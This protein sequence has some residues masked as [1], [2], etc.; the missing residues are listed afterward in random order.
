MKVRRKTARL[1]VLALA[2]ALALILSACAQTTT[3]STAGTTAT[4]KTT[5]K[6]TTSATSGQP[7]ELME[8]DKVSEDVYMPVPDL[9]LVDEPVSFSVLFPRRPEHGDFKTM[10]Y[11]GHLKDTANITLVFEGVEQTGWVEKKNLAFASGEYSDI[12][13]TGISLDDANKY[14]RE[15]MLLRLNDLLKDYSPCSMKLFAAMPTTLKNITDDE[16][17]IYMMPS[18]GINPRDGVWIDGFINEEWLTKAGVAMPKT[19]DDLYIA[20]KA[21][22]TGDGNGNG[23]ED[24]IPL[25]FRWNFNTNWSNYYSILG[26]YGFVGTMHDVIDGNYVYVPVQENYRHFLSYMNKLYAEEL[27]DNEVFTQ[28]TE[29]FTAKCSEYRVGMAG[30]MQNYF[31]DTAKKEAY[32]MVGCLTSEYNQE[33]MWPVR[34]SETTNGSYCITDK[35][36]YPE[37][38]TKL[39]DFFY[40][41]DESFII[42]SGP[43]AGKWDGYG[44]WSR[45][46]QADGSFLS[47]VDWDKDKY[48]SFWLH[49]LATAPM[50]MPFVYTI[51]HAAIVVDSSPDLVYQAKLVDAIGI[52]DYRRLSYPPG[53]SFTQDEQDQL[54]TLVALDNYVQQMVAKFITG[55]SDVS[56]DTEWDAYLS[57]TKALGID[58][59]IQIRQ[60]AYDR[61]SAK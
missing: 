61:W 32:N 56:N 23:I 15:G 60:A 4:T 54:A 13:L 22:K 6:A 14:G 16:G 29:Q 7:F 3:T 11:L 8:R 1:A 36:E 26:A 10:W 42:K 50:D 25:S 33:L 18:Y 24:E 5:T 19:V 31:T 58:T 44:G 2:L 41:Y 35:C 9:P 37:L 40:S 47:S 45:E 51:D 20:L 30:Q 59:V 21:I 27:L 34:T 57:E 49:R 28:T 38:A 46:K 48:T 12:F 43:E 53:V 55:E 17:N 52:V 39:L